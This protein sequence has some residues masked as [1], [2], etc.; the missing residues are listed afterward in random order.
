M[1]IKAIYTYA[2]SRIYA[3]FKVLLPFGHGK[4][5]VYKNTLGLSSDAAQHQKCY[6]ELQQGL[7]LQ[8]QRAF[9]A[10]HRVFTAKHWWFDTKCDNMDY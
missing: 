9:I 5:P 2:E 6:I 8:N 4:R 1:N 3:M 7:D 10:S